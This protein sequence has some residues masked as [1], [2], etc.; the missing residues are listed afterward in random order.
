MKRILRYLKG[1]MLH[2][3]HLKLVILGQ[4]YTLRALCDVDW[5][6]DIEDIRF[7]YG[8]TIYFGPNLIL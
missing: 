4:P 8:A 5:A 2:G 6:F 1:I 7:T 3:L